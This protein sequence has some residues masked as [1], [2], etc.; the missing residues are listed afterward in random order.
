MDISGASWYLER[1]TGQVLLDHED[2]EDLPEDF[3]DDP[4]ISEFPGASR[5]RVR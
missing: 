2:T 4:G 5:R 1:E 3:E